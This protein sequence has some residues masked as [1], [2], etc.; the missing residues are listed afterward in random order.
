MTV[1]S[2]LDVNGLTTDEYRTIMDELG[3]KPDRK[4]VSISI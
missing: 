3:S 2:T 4:G 1:V